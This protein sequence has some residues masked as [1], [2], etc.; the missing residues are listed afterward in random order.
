MTTIEGSIAQIK[1]MANA[2]WDFYD[3]YTLFQPYV[4]LGGGFTWYDADLEVS[5]VERFDM[6]STLKPFPV[7]QAVVGVNINTFDIVFFDLSYRF[8]SSFNETHAN[9]V[10]ISS[11]HDPNV[12][13]EN[14]SV[15]STQPTFMNHVVEIGVRVPIRY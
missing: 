5:S 2:L 1:V 11:P 4:G 7:G 12:D 8:Y 15:N 9:A 13:Y 14:G 10:E 6:E 3:E